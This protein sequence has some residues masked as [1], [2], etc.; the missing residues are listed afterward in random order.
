MMRSGM[1][2]NISDD[3][4]ATSKRFIPKKY[5]KGIKNSK[6][7][8]KQIKGLQESIASYKKG[9]YVDRPALKTYKSKKSSYI[10]QFNEAYGVSITD[11]NA[12]QKA[13][14]VTKKAQE[15]ILKK[16]KGAYYSSGSRPTQTSYSW[17]Y[18]RLAS[19]IMGGK[20]RA[21]DQHILDEEKIVIKKPSI[22][23]KKNLKKKRTFKSK[24]SFKKS[25]KSKQFQD[26]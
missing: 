19:V 3:D 18:G 10:V 15:R 22:K 13:T 21:V 11:K 20:A 5:Y 1:F 23:S 16:G 17:A 7:E 24:K 9:V 25:S 6:E 14:G 26:V 4:G 12:V 2:V 8:K